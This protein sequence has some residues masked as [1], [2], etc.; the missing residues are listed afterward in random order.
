MTDRL[1]EYLKREHTL[2]LIDSSMWQE[3]YDEAANELSKY[4]MRDMTLFMVDEI[5]INPVDYMRRVPT[6]YYYDVNTPKII[7]PSQIQTI[8]DDAFTNSNIESLYLPKML[9]KLCDESFNDCNIAVVW[10]PWS[11]ADYIN[12]VEVDAYAGI[13]CVGFKLGDKDG[14]IVHKLTIPSGLTNVSWNNHF[15]DC[16]SIE[17]IIIEEGVEDIGPFTFSGCHNLTTVELP[18]SMQVIGKE[19]FAYCI[20]LN[21]IIYNGTYEEFGDIEFETD[22]LTNGDG[23]EHWFELVCTDGKYELEAGQTV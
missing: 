8:D 23:T 18:H 6:A 13:F 2:D 3:L 1:K 7:I 19:T 11:I 14:N 12:N 10:L 20:N 21:K 15:Q 9:T 4:E 17:H 5:G 16:T 22:W